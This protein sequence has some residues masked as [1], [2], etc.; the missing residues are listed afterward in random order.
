MFY[1]QMILL[2]LIVAFVIDISGFVGNVRP[3]LNA[4]LHRETDAC[5][6]P[7][8]CSLCMCFW[9]GL[10]LCCFQGFTLQHVAFVCL[11][12]YCERFIKEAVY[13]VSDVIW[14]L[15]RTIS[16]KLT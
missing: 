4:A 9:A 14:S 1:T 10:V 16:D 12:S 5:W 2:A 15:L 13:I 8:D 11:C 7:F 3:A 6:H